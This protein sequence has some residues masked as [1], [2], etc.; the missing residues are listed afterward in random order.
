M[1][2]SIAFAAVCLPLI[3]VRALTRVV[4]QLQ[5]ENSSEMV[6]GVE[7]ST[8]AMEVEE[9][10]T[11]L[12][13][14]DEQL[15]NAKSITVDAAA[16][17][18]DADAAEQADFE[19]NG[20][21]ETDVDEHEIRVGSRMDELDELATQLE[22]KGR[23]WL[24]KKYMKKKYGSHTFKTMIGMGLVE[25]RT[26][27]DKPERHQYALKIN[28]L[29][30]HVEKR[31]RARQHRGLKPPSAK[32]LGL[33]Q[34][35]EETAESPI[36]LTAM[37]DAK[38]D[39]S[40]DAAIALR[41]MA[42]ANADASADAAVDEVVKEASDEEAAGK[43]N[44]TVVNDARQRSCGLLSASCTM[45]ALYALELGLQHHPNWYL[46]L[47]PDAT[48]EDVRAYLAA[49][50]GPHCKCASAANYGSDPAALVG[51]ADAVT[52]GPQ[53]QRCTRAVRWAMQSGIKEHPEWYP[54]MRDN[55]SAVEF[56]AHLLKRNARACQCQASQVESQNAKVAPRSRRS[57]WWADHHQKLLRNR[58]TV[59]TVL[60]RIAN[61]TNSSSSRSVRAA[62]WAAHHKRL[63][64]KTVAVAKESNQSGQGLPRPVLNESNQSAQILT[65]TPKRAGSKRSWLR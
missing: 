22:E 56:H 31:T 18:T 25:Q 62:W 8:K 33:H 15:S 3:S 58:E 28:R 39:A 21:G 61:D 26:N 57:T 19:S 29:R 34:S 1:A 41:A 45:A 43:V 5:T 38:A 44:A 59:K 6:G 54:G 16:V 4:H 50:D 27:P 63:S 7:D 10:R 60:R 47:Q 35:T 2:K 12:L 52:C 51:L 37:A 24:S 32:Q 20:A 55:S 46:G 65:D 13:E 30:R 49:E 42:D 40:A 9:L 53:S 17:T 48:F 36:E 64:N 23:V 14:L 11:R